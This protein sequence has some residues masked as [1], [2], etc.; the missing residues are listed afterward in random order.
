MCYRRSVLTSPLQAW[1][2]QDAGEE[3]IC[4]LLLM[5]DVRLLPLESKALFL[6]PSES[7]IIPPPHFCIFGYSHLFCWDLW[8]Q[9]EPPLQLLWLSSEKEVL[10]GIFFFFGSICSW[11]K[12]LVHLLFPYLYVLFVFIWR[13][14]TNK[15]GNLIPD[16]RN[17]LFLR[18]CPHSSCSRNEDRLER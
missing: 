4:F 12:S 2:E 1:T 13:S 11:A 5:R 14:L 6:R 16:V 15:Q 18:T 8:T 10:H 9:E 17:R 3:G 7:G